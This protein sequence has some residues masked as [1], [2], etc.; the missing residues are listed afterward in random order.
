LG[1]LIKA[2]QKNRSW[3]EALRFARRRVELDAS[4]EARLELA[5]LERATGHRDR[6]T[7]LLTPLTDDAEAGPQ[8]RELLRALTGTEPVAL[9]D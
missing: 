5:R 1:A 3:G 4:P 6:A 9:R 2:L 8:A 7:A